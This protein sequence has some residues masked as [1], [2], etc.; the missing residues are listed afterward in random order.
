MTTVLITGS[1]LFFHNCA[2]II[3]DAAIAFTV[4]ELYVGRRPAWT[5]SLNVA[6]RRVHHLFLAGLLIFMGVIL[7]YACLVVGGVLVAVST[8]VITP[9]IVIENRSAF[10]GLQRSIQLTQGFRWYIFA[11]LAILFLLNSM[12]THL[13]NAI[14]SGS[15]TA[16][17]MWFSVWGSLINMIP[18]SLFVPAFAILKTIIYISIRA[19][20][21]G[22]DVDG[23]SQEIGHD[24][25]LSPDQVFAYQQVSV[26]ADVSSEMDENVA[27][28]PL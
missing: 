15:G 18:A 4:A 1:R 12:V 13:L 14:F 8:S 28:G 10:E 16:Y 25:L 2:A 17:S 27:L 26:A 3:A 21:E 20:K 11:C 7:G 24:G 5:S 23:L 6:L 22:L 19:E 9:V